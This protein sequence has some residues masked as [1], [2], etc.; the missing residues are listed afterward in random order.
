MCNGYSN[1]ISIQEIEEAFSQIHIPLVFPSGAPNLEPR[2]DIRITEQAPIV[3]RN[4]AG[5]TELVQ[6]RWS[7]PAPNGKPVYNFR[8]E[9]RRFTSGRCLIP[10]DGFY[11]FTDPEPPAPK[12]SRKVKWRY[13][14][15][16]EPWFCI[17]GLWRPNPAGDAFT[18]LTS[19]PGRDVLPI[20]NRQVVVLDREDWA[21]W[22]AGAPEAELLRPSAAG[23]LRV[24]RVVEPYMPPPAG[25]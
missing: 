12:R 19:E 11:E 13:T 6:L 16:G 23:T 3:R 21:G 4:G 10:S 18:M 14:K 24:E 7:W 25:V 9:G 2:K 1:T 8:S 5:A 20:H 15:A 22:L 17:A